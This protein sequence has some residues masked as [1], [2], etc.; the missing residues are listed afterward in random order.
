MGRAQRITFKLRGPSADQLRKLAWR[1]PVL[2]HAHFGPDGCDA[3]PLARGLEIPLV[4]TFHGYDVTES[5]EHLPHLYVNRRDRLKQQAASF[6]CVSEFIRRK[7]IERGFPEDRAVVHYTGINTE[8]FRVD[9][10]IERRPIVLFVGRLVENKGC[11][12][13]ISAMADVAKEVA[14]AELVVIGDGRLR[15]QLEAQANAMLGR[16]KFL[17]TQEPACVR[18]WMNRAM[19]LS[20]PCVVTGAGDEEGF[21]MVF[22]EAQAMGLPVV[23]CRNGG[24]PEVVAD[25]ETGLLVPE[26]NAT[27]LA[28]RLLLL[29][30]DKMLRQRFALAGRERV[31][32]LFN[33]RTQA[34]LLEAIYDNALQ[35]W[36]K[37]KSHQ[38]RGLS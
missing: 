3:I 11:Q 6:V 28:R 20:C 29:L 25:G 13:L 38:E 31:E 16:V 12:Y 24:I 1:R 19:V 5:D 33:I 27:A 22:A 30:K 15:K 37:Q 9:P 7:A 2:L 36:P 34:P 32:R 26:R 21:G 17:G 10:A 14:E 18:E 35:T 8:L 23:S 4:V